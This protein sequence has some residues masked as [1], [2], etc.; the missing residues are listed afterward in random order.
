M[1]SITREDVAAFLC[2]TIRYGAIHLEPITKWAD[3]LLAEDASPA[4]WLLSL[5]M[6]GSLEEALDLLRRVPDRPSSHASGNLFMAF[7]CSHWHRRTRKGPELARLAF[8]FIGDHADEA[9]SQQR[10]AA[11]GLHHLYTECVGHRWWNDAETEPETEKLLSP[12]V[13]LVAFLP[14]GV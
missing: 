14:Q 7:L 4:D 2:L 1:S 13:P 10:D 3:A 5:S 11:Y 8:S 6:A 12:F 9:T